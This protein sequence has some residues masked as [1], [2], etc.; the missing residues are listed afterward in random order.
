MFDL[1]PDLPANQHC[2]L[3]TLT[4]NQRSH[5]SAAKLLCETSAEQQES[6]YCNCTLTWMHK[7][8]ANMH[9]NPDT[10]SEYPYTVDNEVI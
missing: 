2:D 10:Y 6:E 3:I 9:P 5:L 8:Y 4:A 7:Q 1:D